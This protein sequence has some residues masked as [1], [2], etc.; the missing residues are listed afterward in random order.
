[1]SKAIAF[2]DFDGTITT[3]DSLAEFIRFTKGDGG[4]LLGLIPSLP[5]IIGFKLG[6]IDNQKAKEGLMSVFFKGIPETEFKDRAVSFVHEKIPAML[7]PGAA[8]KLNWHKQEGHEVVIVSAS[9]T[10]W[11]QPWCELN[12]FACISTELEVVDQKITGKILGQNCHG[13]EKVRRIKEKYDLA[14][15]DAIYAYGDTSGDRPMLA[16]AGNSFYKPFRGK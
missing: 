12:G 3:K 8:A 1:L 5:R 16:L 7:R 6:I 15:Y 2:F 4:F 14:S 9:P 11:L 13:E 10:H